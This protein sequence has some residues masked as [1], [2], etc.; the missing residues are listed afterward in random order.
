M[1]LRQR[2]GRNGK[3]EQVMTVY[4]KTKF[5]FTPPPLTFLHGGQTNLGNTDRSFVQNFD[6]SLLS[7][8]TLLQLITKSEEGTVTNI[9]KEHQINV[10][11]NKRKKEKQHEI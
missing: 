8:A 1:T 7:D 10:T 11:G 6:A 3:T 9:T 4:L 5:C 2:S